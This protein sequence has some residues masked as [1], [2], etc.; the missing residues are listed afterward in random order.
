M[1][2][3]VV[4]FYKTLWWVLS[5]ILLYLSFPP[6]GIPFLGFFA[7]IPSIYR[8]Y[9]D[10]YIRVIFDSL[11]FSIIFWI[12]AVDWFSSFHP[13]ALVAIILPLYLF[14]MFPFAVFSSVSKNFSEDGIILFPFLWVKTKYFP[15][16]E[17]FIYPNISLSI[18]FS[19]V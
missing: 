7:L 15:S 16:W 4:S 18:T 5:G 3:L 1:K 11:V 6:N 10:G 12:L 13:L 17:I 19:K 2:I 14:T 9:K 8:S